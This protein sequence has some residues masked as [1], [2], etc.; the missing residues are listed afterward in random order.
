MMKSSVTNKNDVMDM[1][2]MAMCM[3][4]CTFF[5]MLFVHNRHHL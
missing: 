1:C 2:S 5:D 3:M 4:N